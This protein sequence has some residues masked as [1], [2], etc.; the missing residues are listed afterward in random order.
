MLFKCTKKTV[1]WLLIE[2]HGQD[3]SMEDYHMDTF[4]TTIHKILNQYSEWTFKD[5][6]P[7]IA[8]IAG[9]KGLQLLQ[10][11]DQ[12]ESI[13]K[14][15]F[16]LCV[17]ICYLIVYLFGQ[18]VIGVVE[19]LTNDIMLT[20]DYVK[21][22]LQKCFKDYESKIAG[23]ECPSNI[24]DFII[25]FSGTNICRSLS[26]IH[27]IDNY[28]LHGKRITHDGAFNKKKSK[29]KKRNHRKTSKKKRHRRKTSKKKRNPKNIR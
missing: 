21:T 2:P 18:C 13:H 6:C 9:I 1:L 17:T 19:K 28:D 8:G 24:N 5:I 7:F 12:E 14:V 10:C 16:G 25:K 27:T 3:K 23:Q 15:T 11:M 4:K 20:T 26:G 29:K 22:I